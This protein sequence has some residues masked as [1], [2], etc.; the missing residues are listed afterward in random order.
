MH[1]NSILDHLYSAGWQGSGDRR[2]DYKNL[3]TN[4]L[5]KPKRFKKLGKGLFERLIA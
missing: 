2:K 1:V 5:T 3:F 4:L